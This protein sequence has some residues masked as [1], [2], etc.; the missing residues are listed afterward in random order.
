MNNISIPIT[1]LDFSDLDINLD[2][3]QKKV[4]KFYDQ[5]E[6]DLYLLHK[7]KVDYLEQFINI[8]DNE[9]Y[10]NYDYD[11]SKL[12]INEDTFKI[13]NFMKPT[14]RRLISEYIVEIINDNIFINRQ[15]NRGFT[16]KFAYISNNEFDYRKYTRKF[17]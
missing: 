5:Y 12:N 1:I 17:K 2:T 15:E 7:N 10:L 8:K 11:F 14:R 13:I 6:D 9:V 4:S 3:L 16:Q